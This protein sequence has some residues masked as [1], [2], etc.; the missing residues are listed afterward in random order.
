MNLVGSLV[1]KVVC[2]IKLGVWVQVLAIW[3]QVDT[4]LL[5]LAQELNMKLAFCYIHH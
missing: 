3:T 4:I 2:I 1:S 5:E